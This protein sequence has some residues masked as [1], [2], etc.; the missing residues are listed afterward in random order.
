MFYPICL[1]PPTSHWFGVL[2][3]S[4]QGAEYSKVPD[5]TLPS[6][7]PIYGAIPSGNDCYIAMEN[8][9]RNSQCSH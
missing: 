1:K 6:G 2:L 9:H 3:E 7:V 5:T 8:G 4:L